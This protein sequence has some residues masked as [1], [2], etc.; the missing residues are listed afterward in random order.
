MSRSATV[1]WLSEAIGAAAKSAMFCVS[2]CL[3][4]VEPQ[5]EVKG[6]GPIELPLKPK[7][8]KALLACCRP[9]PYGKGTRTL[10]DKKVRNTFELGPSQFRLSDEWNAAIAGATQLAAEQLGLPGDQLEARLYK[11]LVYKTG[12]F[13]LKHR[14]SE[15]HD[16]MV[17]SMIVALPN[18]FAGGELVVR[19]GGSQQTLTFADAAS[20]TAP[21][22]A[23]FYADCEHEV[24]RVTDG[25]R[26]CLAYNLVL[27]TKRKT[28]LARR[29]IAPADR[30]VESIRSWT[31]N[32]PAT[33]LVFA[34]AHHYT[35]R[36]LSLDLLKGADRRL[37]ETVVSA[38]EKADCLV[39]LTQVSRHLTQS[40]FDESYGEYWR[41]SSQPRGDLDIGETIEEELYGDQWVDI[42]GKKQLWQSIGFD[43]A[44]IVSA[45]PIN[46]WKPTAE[47]YEGYTGNAGN[48]LDRWYHRSAIAVWHRDHHFDVIAHSGAYDSIPLFCSMVARLAKTPKKRLDA[49]RADC[50]RFAQA[51]IARWPR[52]V[53]Y[54]YYAVR[55]K[56]PYDDFLKSLLTLGDG[57]AIARMLSTAAE[58]GRDLRLGSFIVA[59][60]RRFG[61]STF[62]N[63][64]KQLMSFETKH[65]GRDELPPR[66][67]EWLSAFCCDKT[68][69]ADK[70][71]LAG[72]LCALAVNRFCQPRESRAW[73]HDSGDRRESSHEEKSLLPLLKALV[74]AGRDAEL[75]RILK[76]VSES[77]D[78]FRLETCE[79]PCLKAMVP[80]S[81]ERLGSLPPQLTDWL[82]AVRRRLAAATARRPEPP[83]DATRPAEVSCKCQLCAALNAFLADPANRVT[84]IPAVEYDRQHLIGKI[85]KH[86]CDVKHTLE[87]R[88]RP[89]SLVLTKTTGSYDRA[90]KRFEADRRLLRELPALHGARPVVTAQAAVGGGQPRRSAEL[91]AGHHQNL[92]VQATIVNV[93]D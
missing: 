16:R 51:I 46:D 43:L 86:R 50:V 80:W 25:V 33:P 32:Q 29:P 62:A 56:S 70:S 68:E 73:H 31:A 12:G 23:A 88:G 27:K 2:G 52:T 72:K 89:Y 19:H 93:F 11:L 17:A 36:G 37:A 74:A 49:A 24:R 81:Q 78:D 66:D 60:C 15:K 63:E 30:L 39:Y 76:F 42:S 45:T 13:F 21:C 79:V 8:A 7:T 90:V 1:E 20:G 64:L 18:R 47:E 85:D 92:L 6:L 77:P 84:R 67:V 71:S 69:D 48:T 40:A 28:P 41:R 61:W 65:H 5:I 53:G 34:L 4:A 44:A 59:A 91:A 14:D 22:F 75:A 55:E 35:Q 3:P 9:A 54:G 82:A 38:A 58:R 87:K 26:L 57:E 83:A 10:V